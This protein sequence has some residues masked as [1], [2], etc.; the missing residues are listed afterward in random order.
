MTEV[1]GKRGMTIT[2]DGQV[3]ELVSPPSTPSQAEEQPW[4]SRGPRRNL[5]RRKL[6][7]RQYWYAWWK[8][9]FYERVCA[10]RDA[11]PNFAA[12][13][14]ACGRY[15]TLHFKGMSPSSPFQRIR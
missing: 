4:L 5:R 3:W 7:D 6:S 2:T 8:R 13:Y 1:Y 11:L 15:N 9:R 10:R 14:E 12:V